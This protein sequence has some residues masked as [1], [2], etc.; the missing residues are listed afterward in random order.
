MTFLRAIISWIYTLIVAIRHRLYDW[1]VCKSYSFD[2]PIV[3]IGNITVGGTGKTPTAEYLLSVLSERYNIAILSRGYGRST[4]GYREVTTGDSYVDVGDEPLLLKLKF[5]NHPVV[6]CED[7]VAGIERIRKEHPDVNLIVMDD[8]FQHRKVRAKVNLILVDSTRP[9][10][11]DKMLPL[12]RLRDLPSRLQKAHIFIVTK[13]S[14]TMSPIDRRLWTNKLRSVAYQK[15]FFSRHHN[16][17][18]EPLYYF[19]N[20]EEVDYG[21]QAILVTGIGNPRPFVAEAVKR[22]S[23]VE[24]LIFPDHHSFTAEDMKR[25]YKLLNKYPRAIVLMTEKDAVRLR[26][27]KLPESLMRAMYYQPIAMRFIAGPDQDFVGSLIAEIEYGKKKKEAQEAVQDVAE[28]E[29]M[30]DVI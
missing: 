25:I 7:R 8:G 17:M 11:G 16:P 13:C 18:V 9:I 12:G 29:P 27:A 10:E 15:I 1:G 14:T 30:G 6:V 21:R 20:R 3:C 4:K 26:R 23:V 2:I 22:F 19:E 28:G 5:P 24:K